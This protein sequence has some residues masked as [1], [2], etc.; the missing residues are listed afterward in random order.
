ME[1]KEAVRTAINYVKEVFADETLS[2]LGLEEVEY[3]PESNEW[4]VTVGFSRP[5]DYP[6]KDSAWQAWQTAL[7]VPSYK[8]PPERDYKVVHI[9]DTK[10][11]VSA[12][13]NRLI[14]EPAE[15]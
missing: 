7:T 1:V 13:K 4:L 6:R 8:P 5:W 10:G 11:Q 15:V 3:V 12:I 9:D 14:P 2:N